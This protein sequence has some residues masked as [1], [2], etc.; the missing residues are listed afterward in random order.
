M[1]VILLV[2][3]VLT[4]LAAWPSTRTV[5]LACGDKALTVGRGLRY[6]RAYAAI[7]PGTVMLYT[8]PGVALGPQLDIQLKRAGHKV[9]VANDASALRESLNAN[10]VD[11]VLVSVTDAP[12]VEVQAATV[13]SHPSLVCVKVEG[14]KPP[15]S[16]D[17][18]RTCRLKASD[19]A[20]K[21]LTEIDE[22][23]K[24]RIDQSRRTA[25]R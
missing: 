12:A 1:R 4:A 7:H 13:A 3:T 10:A 15:A 18:K 22:V 9:V 2:L 25:Q 23:M 21:F 6:G 24:Q 16:P 5:A 17:P 20:N 11:V 19:Q 8:R 14:E